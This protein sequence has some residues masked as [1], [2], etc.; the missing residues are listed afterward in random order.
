ML[1]VHTLYSQVPNN[2]GG[3]GMKFLQKLIIGGVGTIGGG[4]KK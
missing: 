1:T 3:G 4:G 2:R